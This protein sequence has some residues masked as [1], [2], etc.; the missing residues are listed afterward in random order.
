MSNA[1]LAMAGVVMV[2]R[3]AVVVTEKT[4]ELDPVLMVAV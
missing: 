1:L 3:R 4:P 2:G